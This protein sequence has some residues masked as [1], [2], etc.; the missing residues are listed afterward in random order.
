MGLESGKEE[1]GGPP[2]INVLPKKR[3]A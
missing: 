3:G 1:M 2:L